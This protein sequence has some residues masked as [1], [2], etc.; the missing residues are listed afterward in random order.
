MAMI[1]KATPAATPP[2]IEAA[3]GFFSDCN[4]GAAVADAVVD[5]VVPVAIV[6][7]A[8]AVEVLAPVG[9]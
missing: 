4:N 6:D 1:T 3:E 7:D 5:V 9:L 2:P 8:N